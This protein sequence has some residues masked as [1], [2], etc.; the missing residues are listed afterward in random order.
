MSEPP[1]YSRVEVDTLRSVTSRPVGQP[2]GKTVNSVPSQ[3]YEEVAPCSQLD[4]EFAW[5]FPGLLYAVVGLDRSIFAMFS[6][7][8][9]QPVTVRTHR[10]NDSIIRFGEAAYSGNPWCYTLQG[11]PK[12]LA[13]AFGG[14]VE[15]F[16]FRKGNN[17]WGINCQLT[18][19]ADPFKP[20]VRSGV[21]CSFL[22]PILST[23]G[24]KVVILK[25]AGLLL[26]QP[27][28]GVV[29]DG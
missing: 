22:L 4:P 9:G 25:E 26:D 19:I 21:S 23:L 16:S 10:S 2:H 11:I 17:E 7:A 5:F 28:L 29:T 27:V 6:E 1:K 24:R 20:L 14:Y 3:Y 13:S 12:E 15:S 18:R 8:K